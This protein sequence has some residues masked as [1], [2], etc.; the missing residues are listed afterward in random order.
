MWWRNDKMKVF[1]SWSGVRSK[2]IA[3]IFRDWLP[4]VIQSLDPFVSSEDIKKGSRWNTDIAQQLNDSTFGLICVTKDNLSAPWL[5]FE[6]GAL[7]KSI[8]NNH[9]APLL[10]DVKPSELKDSPISQ[11]Q[12]T[13]FSID[14]MKRL[15]ET[16][17]SAT[18]NSLSAT[19]LNKAF[20][21]CYP[22]LEKSIKELQN[23]SFEEDAEDPDVT[24][25]MYLDPNILEEL[26]ETTRN[27]QRL[28]GNT[29]TKLYSNIDQVQKKVDQ[30]VYQIERQNDINLK[31]SSHKLNRMFVDEIL[32]STHVFDESASIFPYNILIILS[33]YREDFPWI[34]DAGFELVNI[35]KSNVAKKT[36]TAALNKFSRILEFTYRHPIMREMFASKKE[37]VMSLQEISNMITEEIKQQID[38]NI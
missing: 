14:D 5:N 35:I 7:S 36:K 19:R 6:A 38:L 17:N 12:A 1:I 9:V 30:V 31:S 20:E 16:L 18:G 2:K 25:N 22:D 10:F 3:I 27:T 21:L 29:D 32:F 33:I 28:L 34:Y 37:L 23:E 15:I 8:D 4:T 24:S 26:L 11:F 13:S